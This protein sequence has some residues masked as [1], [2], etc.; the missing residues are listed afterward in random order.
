MT[1]HIFLAEFES[2]HVHMIATE[3]WNFKLADANSTYA[4]IMTLEEIAQQTMII[5][6]K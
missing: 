5:T 4:I 2:T 6:A 1:E 3:G